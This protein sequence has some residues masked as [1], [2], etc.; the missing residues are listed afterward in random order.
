MFED[1]L[2]KGRTAMAALPD[3]F[4]TPLQGGI[5][6]VLDGQIVVG[7]D[8]SGGDAPLTR[9]GCIEQAWTVAEVLRAWRAINA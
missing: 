4:F 5:P 6:V 8:V 2:N 9:R 7:V 3:S 1:I